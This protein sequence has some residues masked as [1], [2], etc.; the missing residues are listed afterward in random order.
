[1]KLK[2]N[3]KLLITCDSGA[4]AGKTTAAK[5]IGKK[6]M[7]K[8]K[9]FKILFVKFPIIFPIIYAIIL[10]SFPSLEQILII[11]TI[12]LLAETHFGATWPFFLS[13]T[14]STFLRLCINFKIS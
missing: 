5:L 11:F 10:Y 2:N 1:M 13:K 8:S 9:F 3:I 4:A 12:L 6:K 14:N 7:Y